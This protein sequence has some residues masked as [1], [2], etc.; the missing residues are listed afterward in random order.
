MGQYFSSSNFYGMAGLETDVGTGEYVQI[1]WQPTIFTF[2]INSDTLDIE[3]LEVA[4]L[5]SPIGVETHDVPRTMLYPITF[6]ERPYLYAT[7]ATREYDEFTTISYF[8]EFY[9]RHSVVSANVGDTPSEVYYGVFYLPDA[10]IIYNFMAYGTSVVWSSENNNEPNNQDAYLKMFYREIGQTDS[11]ILTSPSSQLFDV[12]QSSELKFAII[13]ADGFEIEVDANV[14]VVGEIPPNWSYDAD[15]KTLTL[16]NTS[17]FSGVTFHATYETSEYRYKLTV[18]FLVRNS[19]PYLGGGLSTPIGGGGSFGRDEVSDS[20]EVPNTSVAGNLSESSTFTRYLV[21]EAYL[22][23]IGEWLWT[24][25]LGLQI[26]KSFISLLYGDPSQS[27]ISLMSY[28]FDIRSMSGVSTTTQEF[29]WGSHPAGFDAPVITTNSAHV[30]WGAV[31]LQEYWGNFLDY[32][33]HTK[34]QLYLPW[35]TGFVDI[36]PGEVLPGSITVIT[37]IDLLKGSCIHIVTNQNG[38]PIGTYSGQCAQQI[39]MFASDFASKMAGIVTA[40]VA[41]LVGGGTIAASGLAG[42]L[43]GGAAPIVHSVGGRG[44]VT[45]N[46]LSNAAFGAVE[47]GKMTMA[48]QGL[49]GEGYRAAG[50]IATTSLA[51]NR[52]PVHI[53]RSGSFTDGSAALGVQYP[54]LIISRPT[55]SMPNEYGHYFGYPS[56]IYSNL[57][58]LRGYTEVGEIHLEGFAAT[59]AELAE[60]DR[61]LKG[62]VIL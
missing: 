40:G 9:G 62:G 34:I 53:S 60:I 57:G 61:L 32:A 3:N 11:L 41:G 49:S 10:D 56:N 25:T 21:N 39:P 17:S 37:N 36:D 16:L 18:T 20:I 7:H 22:D 44:V 50:R 23:I 51:V 38:N 35:G 47:A 54:Y 19:N 45:G 13:G 4:L 29:Y 46:R 28:P 15:T 52:S 42:A 59:E 27:I 55:Q 1:S 2:D 24:D 31:S 48:G 14:E 33:P 6:G 8:A 26:A 5:G 30:N 43:K 12:N 58:I